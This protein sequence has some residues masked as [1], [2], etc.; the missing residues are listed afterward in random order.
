[1]FVCE[2]VGAAQVSAGPM[3]A[4]RGQWIPLELKLQD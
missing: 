3:E 2:R 4:S 1:M